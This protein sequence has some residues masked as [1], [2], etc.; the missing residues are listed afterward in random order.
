M[1]DALPDLITIDHFLDC[2]LLKM[3]S[4][5]RVDSSIFNQFNPEQILFLGQDNY[6]FSEVVIEPKTHR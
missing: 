4:L 5:R 6:P 2:T 3:Q 1:E